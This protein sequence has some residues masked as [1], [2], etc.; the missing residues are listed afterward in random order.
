MVNAGREL[1]LRLRMK[2][3]IVLATGILLN[4]PANEFNPLDCYD[5]GY[6][7]LENIAT[8]YGP[9]PD[10]GWILKDSNLGVAGWYCQ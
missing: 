2:I 1:L 3:I 6:T 9:G 4:F 5:Q 7:I 10:Q 8:Y